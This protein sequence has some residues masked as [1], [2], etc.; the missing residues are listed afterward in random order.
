MHDRPLWCRKD[1]FVGEA[2]RLR[3][4]PTSSSPPSLGEF[5]HQ[6]A[7]DFVVHD[8]SEAERRYDAADSRQGA[9]APVLGDGVPPLPRGR[10]RARREGPVVQVQAEQ[11]QGRADQLDGGGGE[12]LGDA[13]AAGVLLDA[14]AEVLGEDGAEERGH[15]EGGEDGHAVAEGEE[16]VRGQRDGARGDA[17]RAEQAHEDLVLVDAHA[18]VGGGRGGEL[19]RAG[20]DERDGLVL[21]RRRHRVE[22]VGR[23]VR[24]A[25]EHE[26]EGKGLA[27]ED[28]VR[29]QEERLERCAERVA[30]GSAA[31]GVLHDGP[32]GRAR[33]S[34]KVG[35]AHAWLAC[36]RF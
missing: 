2:Y 30:H 26:D 34:D 23:Q 9:D 16:E 10:P 8:A 5:F 28:A 19:G 14:G 4:L 35:G 15:V 18:D 17:G 12:E 32:D 6:S 36:G 29:P 22:R 20:G 7:P 21:H 33:V 3:P 25:V 27:E 31:G 1:A 13:L 24:A 11:V